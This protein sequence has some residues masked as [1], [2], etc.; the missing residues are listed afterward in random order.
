M[1]AQQLQMVQILDN[2]IP[3]H[4]QIVLPASPPQS[5]DVVDLDGSSSPP[6]L[7]IHNGDLPQILGRRRARLSVWF[8]YWLGKTRHFRDLRFWLLTKHVSSWSAKSGEHLQEY[9]AETKDV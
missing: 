8:G 4:S 9:A 3:V 6:P 2:S 5:D 1:A 7:A